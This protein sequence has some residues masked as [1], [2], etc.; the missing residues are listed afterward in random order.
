MTNRRYDVPPVAL[1]KK[2]LATPEGIALIELLERIMADGRLA[3]QE[4]TEL[5]AWL[6]Q[7]ASTSTLPGIHFLR[8]GSRGNSCRRCSLGS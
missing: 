4:I 5:A 1:S 6:E 3:D 2:S 8:E 7:T